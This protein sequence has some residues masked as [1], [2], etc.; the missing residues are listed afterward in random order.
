MSIRS[1]CTACTHMTELIITPHG[2]RWAAAASTVVEHWG[3]SNCWPNKKY[4][5]DTHRT[6]IGTCRHSLKKV[7]DVIAHA[8]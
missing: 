8:K 7:D 2:S 4:V 1:W 3:K 5:T 6:L